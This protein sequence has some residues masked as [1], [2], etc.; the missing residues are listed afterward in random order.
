EFFGGGPTMRTQSRFASAALGG[1]AKVCLALF[2][3][4]APCISAGQVPQ[5]PRAAASRFAFH[6]EVMGEM[7]PGSEY[8]KAFIGNFHLAWA[9][10]Q[11]GTITVRLDGKQQGQTYKDAS[12]LS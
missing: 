5:S 4:A 6:E 3:G 9:E 10:S 1:R 7:S 2:F 8:K 11:S 12:H